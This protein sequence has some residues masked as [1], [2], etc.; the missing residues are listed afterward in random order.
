LRADREKWDRRYS[1]E[2]R[3]VPPP[4]EFLVV[5]SSLLTSGIALDLASGLGGDALFLAE[6]G[7][8]VHAVDISSQALS[9]LH[10]MARDRALDIQP[11]IADLDYF[12][13]PKSFYD[14]IVVFYFFAEG[15]MPEITA[16]VKKGG[17]IWY[18]TYNQRHT[19]VKPGFN[20]DYLVPPD[21]LV[22][23]FSGFDI[24]VHE[25]DAGPN[26]NISRVLARRVDS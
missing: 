21:G 12:H 14:V 9:R 22:Q 25:T 2:S 17:L 6:R 16:A 1:R 11:V 23:F 15:M 4:D 18:A 19:S 7:Y 10:K 20:P 13:L 26:R 5:H 8:R 3:E 24:L